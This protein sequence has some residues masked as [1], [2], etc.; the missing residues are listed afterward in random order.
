MAVPDRMDV[1]STV[2]AGVQDEVSTAGMRELMFLLCAEE[3]WS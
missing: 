2:E 1:P 3:K